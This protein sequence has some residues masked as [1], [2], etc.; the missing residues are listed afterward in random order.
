MD[1]EIRP[2]S[3]VQQCTG[4]GPSLTALVC[5]DQGQVG[6]GSGSR[7]TAPGPAS[8]TGNL[9]SSRS[10]MAEQGF[11]RS[12]STVSNPDNLYSSRSQMA[13][14]QNY[15]RSVSQSSASARPLLAPE[16]QLS[17]G[18]GFPS[19][20][21]LEQQPGAVPSWVPRNYLDKVLAITTIR[22]RG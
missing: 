19:E 8:V 13:A 15:K 21:Q 10:K 3:R 12:V 4:L 11:T 18:P 1:P 7:H 14:D 17:S 2:D 9:Y 20:Q 6:P 16:P 22:T 5:H